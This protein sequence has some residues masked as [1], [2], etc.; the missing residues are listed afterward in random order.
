[1]AEAFKKQDGH[2]DVTVNLIEATDA[3]GNKVYKIDAFQ[4][5]N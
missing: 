5:L 1:M 2:V 4:F 3:N